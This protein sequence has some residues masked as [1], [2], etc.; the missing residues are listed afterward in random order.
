MLS[1]KA[2][3]ALKPRDELYR[4]ADALGLVI[5]VTPNGS[6]LWR[7]RYRVGGKAQMLALGK[8]PI[9][10]LQLAR[11]KAAEAREKI[12]AGRDPGA[13]RKDAKTR[14]AV[15]PDTTFEAIARAWFTKAYEG[16]VQT[17]VAKN[18]TFL[19]GDVYP[20]IGARQIG[21]IKAGDLLTVIRRIESRGALDIARR[22]HNLIGRV[23]KFAVAH[24][25][26]ERNPAQD[27]NLGDILPQARE[28]HHAAITDPKEVGALLRAIDGFTGAYVTRCALQLAPLVFVR[29]GELRMAEWQEIDMDVAEWRI[30]ASKMKM[31][32]K[33]IVPLSRQ[34]IA[35]LE[36]IRQLTGRGRY[37]FPGERTDT[38]P[39]SENT[40]NAA[41]RRMGYS[42][43]EMTGHGFRSLASTLLH[44]MGYPHVVIER[45]LAH[46]ERNKVAAAY[47]HAEYLPE[48]RAMMQVWS[49][50][51]MALRDG[52]RV[53]P[54][55]GNAA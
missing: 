14:D 29:P 30:P 7:L 39:M 24:G 45:Q 6:K 21:D 23:F 1:D 54:L 40:I 16:R 8:Y 50:Y 11:A 17:T 55:R 33:H 53:I 20:W 37:I 26:C 13:E 51:L 42:K 5:E 19:E 4:V 3:Q 28:K 12:S 9:T 52:S 27:I 10:G 38:R 18:R 44:E 32:G 2:I 46:S 25:F 15:V 22:T 43:E 41:L 31:R 36:E 48:R 35:I 34:A 47:N 49:D